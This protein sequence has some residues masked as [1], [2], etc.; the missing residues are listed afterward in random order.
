MFKRTAIVLV[1]GAAALLAPI[2]P[3]AAQQTVNFSLG[4]YTLRG[5]D[6]RVSGDVL[7]A[8]RNFL[9][10]DIHDLNGATLGGEWLVPLTGWFEGGIGV[11]YY[12]HTVPSVYASFVN[13][14]GSEIEQD[15]RLRVIPV[16]FTVRVVP[17]GRETAIQPYVGGGLAVYSWR[18]SETG[19]FVDF[20]DDSIF[21]D[22]FVKS[23]SDTGPVA[24]G[25]IRFAA[26]R[27]S[28]GFELRYQKGEGTLDSRFAGDKIDL[29][30]YAANW[31]I[32][33]R[34]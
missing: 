3:A 23:G 32:G 13:R 31:T 4:R 11:G 30:G 25:G 6:A 24:L 5:E 22:R 29:G 33:V 2:P 7:S 28:T 16:S 14:D 17:F 26:D 8:N 21:R 34:F 10:F 12:R 1:I 18:Y 20:R 15:L 27:L 9:A 19:Q